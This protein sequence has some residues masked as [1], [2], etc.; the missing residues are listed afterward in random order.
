MS[1]LNQQKG[2]RGEQGGVS[3]SRTEGATRISPDLSYRKDKGE[4]VKASGLENVTR[5]RRDK[6]FNNFSN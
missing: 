4:A 1:Q 5:F 3:S 2:P 6:S